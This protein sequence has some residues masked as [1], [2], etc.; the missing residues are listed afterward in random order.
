MLSAVRLPNM[1]T[2][3]WIPMENRWLELWC[4]FAIILVHR[5][6]RG[7]SHYAF[8]PSGNYSHGHNVLI[9]M[10]SQNATFFQNYTYIEIVGSP[11]IGN[12][13]FPYLVYLSGRLFYSSHT[14]CLFSISIF[15]I[16]NSFRILVFFSN[17][18]H[19]TFHFWF[20]DYLQMPGI[21]LRFDSDVCLDAYIF[22][23]HDLNNGFP[24]VENILKVFGGRNT[25]C[26]N[27]FK[28]GFN[29]I[30]CLIF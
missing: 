25:S 11:N 14:L 9:L 13:G 30:E 6:G 12:I 15:G 24:L 20:L 5:N 26:I 19:L 7:W 2:R 3:C 16:F 27:V 4:I 28:E 8:V 29:N 23:M 18:A 10:I 21:L 1:S 17:C 22:K